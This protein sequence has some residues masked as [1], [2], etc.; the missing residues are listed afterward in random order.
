MNESIFMMNKDRAKF[1][2]YG[3]LFIRKHSIMLIKRSYLRYFKSE[4]MPTI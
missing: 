4:E 2:V 1:T 3:I